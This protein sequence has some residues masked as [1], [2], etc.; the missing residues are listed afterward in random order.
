MKEN[1]YIGL[2]DLDEINKQ[3][4]KNKR[5][6]KKKER[7]SIFERLTTKENII[8]FSFFLI[9]LILAW[10]L[11]KVYNPYSKFD[12]REITRDTLLS[13]SSVEYNREN[14]WIL[15]NILEN[16]LNSSV[17]VSS[18]NT[19]GEGAESSLHYKY[20]TEEYYE[21]LNKDYKVFLNKKEYLQLANNVINNY[22]EN[23][24]SLYTVSTRAPIRNIYKLTNYGD[25]YFLIRLN[26]S[27]ESYVGISIDKSSSTFEIFYLE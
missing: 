17:T 3:N 5:T 8:I 9:F 19:N 14:Y 1:R 20:S 15:N 13:D 26:T 22:K 21:T 10:N 16:F 6:K 18:E 2:E 12:Y 24:E 11:V 27:V 23:Y 4:E 7:K 25:N